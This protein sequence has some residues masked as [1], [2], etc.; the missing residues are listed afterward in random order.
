MRWSVFSKTDDLIKIATL[1][2]SWYLKANKKLKMKLH[3]RYWLIL[4]LGFTISC[5][6]EEQSVWLDEIG[7]EH[8]YERWGETHANASILGNPIRIAGKKYDRGVGTHALS[9]CIV[10]L[11]GKAL[12]FNSDVGIDDEEKGRGDAEFHV[13][14]DGKIAWTSGLMY[15][16]TVK[17]VNIDLKGAKQLA[18]V[19]TDG[20]NGNGYDHTNWA[21][22]K[23]TFEGEKP[24]IVPEMLINKELFSRDGNDQQPVVVTSGILEGKVN[25]K[26]SFRVPVAGTHPIRFSIPNCPQEVKI[27][28]ETGELTAQCYEPKEMRLRVEVEN[29]F[30]KDYKEILLRIVPQKRQ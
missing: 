25:E 12:K 8:I 11:D 9:T 24:A 30:G 13:I 5:K 10:Q 17:H 28:A 22:A 4:L 26:L 16:G 21:N 7:V 29:D 18:L 15:A 1:N 20:G 23:I 3:F 2:T 27:N 14:V 6:E 19:T